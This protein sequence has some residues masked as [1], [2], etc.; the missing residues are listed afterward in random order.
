[1]EISYYKIHIHS[2]KDIILIYNKVKN[3]HTT[4]EDK[5]IQ[6]I[7]NFKYK[8]HTHLIVMDLR[9]EGRSL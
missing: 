6:T 9:G 2:I 8:L 7:I 3:I 5:E 4:S 1:M